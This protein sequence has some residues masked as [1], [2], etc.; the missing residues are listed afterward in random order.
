MFDTLSNV[1]RMGLKY[2]KR[3]CSEPRTCRSTA[4]S[5]WFRLTR[6]PAAQ[7]AAP[8]KQ[9]ACQSHLKLFRQ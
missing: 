9:T 7:Q 3:A 4:S 8:R 6:H 1:A 5:R 2:S